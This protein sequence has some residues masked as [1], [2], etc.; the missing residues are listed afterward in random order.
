VP[1][2]GWWRRGGCA[3]HHESGR[4]LD[5]AGRDDGRRRVLGAAS[6]G[7]R[8]G[9]AGAPAGGACVTGSRPGC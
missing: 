9:Q 4:E 1:L 8:R 2:T 5:A 3:A 7:A 6:P